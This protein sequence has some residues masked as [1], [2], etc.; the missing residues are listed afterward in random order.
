MGDSIA[1]WTAKA[2]FLRSVNASEGAWSDDD[3]LVRLCLNPD[4]AIAVV[5]S[6]TQPSISPQERERLAREERRALASRSSGGPVL[7]LNG[8]D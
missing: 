4:A 6:E 5:D 3:T 2:E 7:R 8:D 1:Q